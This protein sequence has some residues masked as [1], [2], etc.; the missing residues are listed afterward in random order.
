MTICYT[1]AKGQLVQ[2]SVFSLCH[3]LQLRQVSV[4]KSG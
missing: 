1:F 3:K 2:H 4:S